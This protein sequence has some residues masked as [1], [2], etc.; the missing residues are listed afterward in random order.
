[1]SPLPAASVRLAVLTVGLPCSASVIV[2]VPS[3]DN[4]ALGAVPVPIIDALSET[5]PFEPEAPM[6]LTMLPL[7][8]PATFSV[9]FEPVPP[10]WNVLLVPAE[11]LMLMV[12]LS[13]S[14]T[15]TSLLPDRIRVPAVV[16]IGEEAEPKA[17]V[18]LSLKVRDGIVAEPLM[19]LLEESLMLALLPALRSSEVALVVSDMLVPAVAI[20]VVVLTLPAV[21]VMLVPVASSVTLLLLAAL[22]P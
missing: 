9:F 5:D 4:A 6:R 22:S 13:E 21:R 12:L 16:L 14:V 18:P 11:P 17:A 7:M 1:M 2:P 10:I 15:N 20:N 19:V 8:L 3:A